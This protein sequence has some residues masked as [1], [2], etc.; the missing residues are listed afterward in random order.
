MRRLS[1]KI[2]MMWKLFKRAKIARA[3]QIR[4]IAGSG[5]NIS[6]FVAFEKWRRAQE[7]TAFELFFPDVCY[8]TKGLVSW[9]KRLGS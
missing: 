8:G 4:L 3:E 9:W 1:F 6:R 7:V 5:V 2:L